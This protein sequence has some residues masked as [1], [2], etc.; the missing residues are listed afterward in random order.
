MFRMKMFEVVLRVRVEV[1]CMSIQFYDHDRNE[2]KRPHGRDYLSL[3][4]T[5]PSDN[6]RSDC[7]SLSST[8]SS[9]KRRSTLSY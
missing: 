2:A 4:L 3:I 7:A 8:S 5:V 9:G 6:D 1:Y